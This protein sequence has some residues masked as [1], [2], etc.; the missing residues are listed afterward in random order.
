MLDPQTAN[1]EAVETYIRANA[2]VT[3]FPCEYDEDD[4]QPHREAMAWYDG[5]TVYLR[6]DVVERIPGVTLG[7]TAVMQAFK[8]RGVL[9]SPKAGQRAGALQGPAHRCREEL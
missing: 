6:T 4:P 2:G 7:R 1:M 8:D 9:I 5:T 3:V